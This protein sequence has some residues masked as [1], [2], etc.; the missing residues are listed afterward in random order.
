MPL[1]EYSCGGCRTTFEALVSPSSSN[2]TEQACPSCGEKARRILSVANFSPGRRVP[3][4]MPNPPRNGKPDVT[5]LKLAPA[6]RLCWMDDQSAARLAAY[7]AGRGA[8]YDDIV[9]TRQELTQNRGEEPVQPLHS[10]SPL[11][12]PVVLAHRA[13]AARREKIVE[14]AAIKKEAERKEK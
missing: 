4:T 10:D 9:A 5:R 2:Q 13:Q 12:D 11:S 14:S 3:V 7:K 6:A 8:E 1:Y